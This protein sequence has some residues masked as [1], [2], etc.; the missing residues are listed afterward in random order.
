MADDQTI[1]GDSA[2]GFKASSPKADPPRAE[3]TAPDDASKGAGAPVEEV[4]QVRILEE[5]IVSPPAKISE[6]P[7][8]TPTTQPIPATQPTPA[9][10]PP[11]RAA[12]ASPPKTQKDLSPPVPALHTPPSREDRIA[13]MSAALSARMDPAPTPPTPTTKPTASPPAATPA[14]AQTAILTPTNVQPVLLDPSPTAPVTKA[15]LAQPTSG[16]DAGIA[17]IVAE[18]K[19]PER[20]QPAAVAKEVA[21]AAPEKA[22][23]E[24]STSLQDPTTPRIIPPSESAAPAPTEQSS[25]STLVSSIVAPF[26]TLRDDLQNIVRVKKISLVRAAALEQDKQR[27]TSETER[28]VHERARS[29]RSFG[30]LF[31]VLLLTVV[32]AAALFGVYIIS[33][34][35]GGSARQEPSSSIL[36]AENT[37]G[38][39]IEGKPAH[40]IKRVLA[41]SRL[42]SSGTLG[43]ITRIAPTVPLEV[44]EGVEPGV[45]EATLS[46]FFIALK[47]RAS[48]SLLRALSPQFFFGLHTVD[49]NA[50]LLVIPVVSYEHAFAGMIAWEQTMNGDLAPIFTAVSDQVVG[51]GGLLEKR[52][53][54]DIV[55]RNYDVRALKNDAGQ[56]ELYYSFPT[57]RLLVI[58]E[59]PYSF[60]EI[61]SRLRAERKL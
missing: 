16:K 10:A 58:A 33:S 55:M 9:P 22:P 31:T 8:V 30:I 23:L 25:G 32:G 35:R 19:L 48:E 60:T 50:P 12:V 21:A 26:R 54:E 2:G 24:I 13:S 46:E 59:S 47:T 36:F 7:K 29:K 5:H 14:S 6:P 57:Q 15:Q 3:T 17:R 49:E 11:P 43:S 51:S 56:I 39:P 1:A 34:E 52:R 4:P 28:G 40:E 61:L 38:L 18:T 20:V 53:F 41:Q 42:S 44:V 37:L 45:R 27:H